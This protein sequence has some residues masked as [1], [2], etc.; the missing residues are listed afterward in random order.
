LHKRAATLFDAQV[1]QLRQF[2][3]SPTDR[4]PP[5][6]VSLDQLGFG[7]QL[8]S[9]FK[10]TI[11]DVLLKGCTYVAPTVSDHI[12]IHPNDWV[13]A[14]SC[15]IHMSALEIRQGIRSKKYTRRFTDRKAKR[16]QTASIQVRDIEIGRFRATA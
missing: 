8:R 5:S 2:R 11:H 7:G 16:L 13:I 3:N 14:K 12:S 6:P 10:D 9:G 15:D 1:A 4:V